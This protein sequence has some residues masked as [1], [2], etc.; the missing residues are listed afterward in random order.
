MVALHSQVLCSSNRI[1]QDPL[2]RESSSRAN[3]YVCSRQQPFCPFP[4]LITTNNI[5]HWISVTGGVFCLYLHIFVEWSTYVSCSFP[6]FSQ[7]L[8]MSGGRGW[9]QCCGR[10]SILIVP[11]VDQWTTFHPWRTRNERLHCIYF[12]LFGSKSQNDFHLVIFAAVHGWT[13]GINLQMYS[14]SSF[15]GHTAFKKVGF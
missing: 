6:F 5:W 4:P 14:L 2:S 12:L 7:S 3:H 15:L 13:R 8:W 11:I 10:K 9:H 1:H